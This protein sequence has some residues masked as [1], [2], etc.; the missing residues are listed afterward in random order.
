MKQTSIGPVVVIPVSTPENMYYKTGNIYISL[1]DKSN[2]VMYRNKDGVMITEFVTHMPDAEYIQSSDNNKS[3]SGK[4]VIEEWNGKAKNGFLFADNKVYI[5][6]SG[7]LSSEV[8]QVQTAGDRN[9]VNGWETYCVTTDYYSY[10][11]FRSPTYEGSY[12]DC[13]TVYIDEPLQSLMP[14]DYDYSGGGGGG[15]GGGGNDKLTT[16]QPAPCI[17]KDKLSAAAANPTVSSHDN[18]ILSN[19]K[20]SAQTPTPQEYGTERN[21][22][23]VPGNTYMNTQVRTDG[24]A[25]SFR[26]T[27][28]WNGISGYTIGASHGHPGNS[29][30]SPAD[31]LWAYSNIN[32]PELINSNGLEFYKNNV[33]VTIVTDYGNFVVTIKDWSALGKHYNTYYYDANSELAGIATFAQLA[34]SYNYNN[35]GALNPDKTAYALMKMYGDAINLYKAYPGSTTFQPLQLNSQDQITTM[36]CI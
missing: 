17:E 36:P 20:A 26:P 32:R 29:A 18:Q 8:N 9:A 25:N 35:P 1:K 19:T 15:G 10:T 3:F 33:N 27:F 5:S 34:Q 24:S 21:L 16:R 14:A 6:K 12:T 13:Y 7:R 30:P 22:T 23:S 31:A 4:I 28:S 11:D 2:I